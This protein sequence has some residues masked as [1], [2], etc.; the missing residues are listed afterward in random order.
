MIPPN[1]DDRRVHLLALVA[2]LAT[3]TPPRRRAVDG[4]MSEHRVAPGT[5]VRSLVTKTGERAFRVAVRG[6][7]VLH[8]TARAGAPPTGFS[9]DG[10]WWPLLE[11]LAAPWR[12][13]CGEA[14]APDPAPVRRSHFER[15]P[16]SARAPSGSA[17]LTGPRLVRL[18]AE[19]TASLGVSRPTGGDEILFPIVGVRGQAW[20]LRIGA[21]LHV[22]VHH[23]HHLL[24][25]GTMSRFDL[26]RPALTFHRSCGPW[27]PQML[28]EIHAQADGIDPADLVKFCQGGGT[29]RP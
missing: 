16:Y 24:L 28:H 14:T 17:Q 26:N 1:G 6:A 29:D 9:L 25:A 15:S 19:C 5:V 11:A 21:E 3:V 22:L 18:L 4:S 10:E 27:L 8:L 7:L 2:L 13:F 12:A 20:I 23:G